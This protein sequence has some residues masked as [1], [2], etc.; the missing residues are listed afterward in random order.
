MNPVL[1][2]SA[3]TLFAGFVASKNTNRGTYKDDVFKLRKGVKERQEVQRLD[4][5][6]SYAAVDGNTK[7][8]YVNKKKE[9]RERFIRHTLEEIFERPF[10]SLRPTWLR[11]PE[12]NRFLELDCYNEEMRLPFEI[13]GIQHYKYI[14]YFHKSYDNFVKIQGRDV[15]KRILCEKRGLTLIEISFTVEDSKLGEFILLAVDKKRIK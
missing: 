6:K 14:P 9:T 2:G 10:G 1:L 15:M 7:V 4:E 13:Q 8:Y 12:T 11:N 5:E 3:F